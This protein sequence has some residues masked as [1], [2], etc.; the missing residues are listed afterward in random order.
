[1]KLT[2]HLKAGRSRYEIDMTSG[3]LLGKIVRY[4]IP[5]ALSGLLQ[6]LF[7]AADMVVV[8]RFAGS[9][10]L[11][12]VGATGSIINLI[13]TLFMG[14][15]IGTNVLVAQYYGA[16]NNKD[17]DETVHTSILASVTSGVALIAVGILLAKPALSAMGTPSEVL[18]QSVLYMRIYFVGVPVMLLYN[19]GA[20]ILRAVGDTQRPLYF[21]LLAGVVNVILNLIFVIV[22][23]MGVAGVATATVISQAI[24]AGLVLWCLMKVN[25]P[26]RVEIKRLR[27]KRDKLIAMVR[28]GLPAGIQGASFSISNVLIQSTINSFGS[29]AMAGN[30]AAA[31]I[32]GFVSVGQ[33]SFSQAALSFTGQNLG[34]KKTERIN[35]ILVLC[36]VLGVGTGLLMGFGARLFGYQL[37]GIYSSD[38][39]VVAYG[40]RRMTIC[41]TTQCV[42]AMMGVLVSVLRGMGYSFIPMAIIMTFVCGFRVVWLYTVFR[43]LPTLEMLYVSYPITWALAALCDAVCYFIIKRRVDKKVKGS[44]I[45]ETALEQG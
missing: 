44:G 20:A 9:T 31:N 7:N 23:H 11:A 5:L 25:G 8:G 19:F 14:L 27:I 43:L 10:A 41:C 28:I 15:S 22:F 45:D 33:D 32:E 39:E 13:V 3:P 16:G 34:A 17:L 6:L 24:S 4:A 37:L 38:P 35:R 26:Y 36:M 30:T 1:M 12:A 18:D 29:I 42:G 2:F 40:I 21:L